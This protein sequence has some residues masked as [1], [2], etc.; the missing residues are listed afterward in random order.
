[1]EKPLNK[2]YDSIKT[3]QSPQFFSQLTGGSNVNTSSGW[4][5]RLVKPW[6]LLLSLTGKGEMELD[7]ESLKIPEGSLLVYKPGYRYT[8]RALGEW[9]YI[10]FHY[11]IRNH[12]IGEMDFNEVLPG[13]GMQVFEGEELSRIQTELQ[14][15]T[16][17]EQIHRPGWE[18][19]ALLLVETALQ[20]FI[21][22]EQNAQRLSRDRIKH[23][24]QLLTGSHDY[25]MDEVASLC[26]ISVPLLY[27]NFRREMG[28]SPRHYR[29]Q[30]FL[31][32][33][34]KM[35]LNTNLGLEEVAEACH[36]Y[37]RYYFSTRFKKHFGISPGAFR[38]GKTAD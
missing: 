28:C 18:L 17:L 11:P 1:M 2:M 7:G 33:G 5:R 22:R 34:K 30:F 26:G 20:R 24:V 13:L 25:R 9:H 31:R 3:A 38:K 15:A 37:D 35:L 14:E 23:A 19:L 29:E 21:Q 32:K 6:G 4:T 36:F 10:W 27:C 12:M 16:M 8:F